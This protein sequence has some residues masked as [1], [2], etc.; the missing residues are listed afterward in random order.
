MNNEYV[1]PEGSFGCSSEETN[2]SSS[3]TETETKKIPSHVVNLRESKTHLFYVIQS[4]NE[5][6]DKA[7]HLVQIKV[8]KERPSSRKFIAKKMLLRYGNSNDVT[9][10]NQEKTKKT[11]KPSL[12]SIHKRTDHPSFVVLPEVLKGR[13][14]D[15]R[16][17]IERNQ[18]TSENSNETYVVRPRLENRNSKRKVPILFGSLWKQNSPTVD[19]GFLHGSCTL[20]IL[21]IVKIEIF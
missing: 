18:S 16:Q 12:A 15:V 21:K 9:N 17:T 2:T 11:R 19:A 3:T 10:E 20:Y 4:D 6:N 5:N 7:K 1:V 8:S 13:H 14:G